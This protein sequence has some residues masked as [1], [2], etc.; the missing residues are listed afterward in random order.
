MTSEAGWLA[1]PVLLQGTFHSWVPSPWVTTVAQ[2]FL[3]ITFV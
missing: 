2:C 3:G 1:S